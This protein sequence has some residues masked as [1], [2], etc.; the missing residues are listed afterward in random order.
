MSRAEYMRNYRAAKKEAQKPN[1]GPV[2]T[3]EGVWHDVPGAWQA[4]LDQISTLEAEVKHLKGLVA[5][6]SF[7]SR[8]FTPAPKTKH[9]P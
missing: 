5:E 3:P 6:R 9:R 7:N 4:L 8:P 1:L 2:Q